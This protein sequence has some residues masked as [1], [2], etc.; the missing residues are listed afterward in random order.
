M[1]WVE[2]GFFQMKAF[3]NPAV[4]SHSQYVPLVASGK[5]KTKTKTKQ[6]SRREIGKKKKTS[7]KGIEWASRL[8]VPHM[9]FNRK[10]DG[11]IFTFLL[12]SGESFQ[13][14]TTQYE[15]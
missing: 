11:K 12:I 14:F 15:T 4:E 8:K 13:Y 7:G 10:S 1:L 9:I 5:T 3:W 2:K 6:K